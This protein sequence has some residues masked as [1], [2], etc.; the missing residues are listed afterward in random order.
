MNRNDFVVVL[1]C[2]YVHNFYGQGGVSDYV[3]IYVKHNVLLD[4]TV[5]NLYQLIRTLHFEVQ[6]VV[7]EVLRS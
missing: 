3:R 2:L 6:S 4:T 7:I 5:I 1:V